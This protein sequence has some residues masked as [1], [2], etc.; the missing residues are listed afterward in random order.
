MIY[1][2]NK[3]LNSTLCAALFF[4]LLLLSS[5]RAAANRLPAARRITRPKKNIFNTKIH[6]IFID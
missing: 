4:L 6:A 1:I 2:L 5:P 3:G